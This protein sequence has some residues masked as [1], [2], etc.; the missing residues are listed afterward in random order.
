MENTIHR[1][2]ARSGRSSGAPS[3]SLDMSGKSLGIQFTNTNG[4]FWFTDLKPG[5]YTVRERPDLIDRNDL[6]GDG[7]PDIVD[8]N[9][10]GYPEFMGNGI[11]DTKEGLMISTPIETTVQIWSREELVWTA[12]ARPCWAVLPLSTLSRINS[13]TWKDT[14]SPRVREGHVVGSHLRGADFLGHTRKTSKPRRLT[15]YLARD[16]DEYDDEYDAIFRRVVW[17]LRIPGHLPGP[18]STCRSL[19]SAST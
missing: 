19:A 3:N 9:G 8:K 11:P 7:H 6:D 16:V 5:K 13:R 12:P 14:I 18:S 10:D 4:E 1:R 15:A 17:L 2:W